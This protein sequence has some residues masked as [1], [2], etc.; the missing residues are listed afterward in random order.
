MY[1]LKFVI[2]VGG[3]DDFG[4]TAGDAVEEKG[5]TDEGS[6]KKNDGLDGIGPDDCGESTDE[7][8]KS[9]AEA[10][11]DEDGVDVPSEDDLHGQRHEIED[12]GDTRDVEEEIKGAGENPS[13]GAEAIF[14]Q[15]VGGDRSASSVVGK[16]VTHRDDGDEGD[17]ERE[18]EG[19][20]I[21]GEGF[22][23]EGEVA[24]GA[25]VGGEDGEAANP[26]G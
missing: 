24:D 18:G 1:L 3:F 7:R 6:T 25:D 12:H 19:V 21:S 5:Q 16:E 26:A 20:P 8:V 11:D 15:F 14:Q 9:D 17:G 13:P 10:G 22:S 4:R 23:G 2:S